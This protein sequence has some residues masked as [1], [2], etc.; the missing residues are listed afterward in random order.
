MKGFLHLLTRF[1][2]ETSALHPNGKAPQW[3]LTL[4]G[5][6]GRSGRSVGLCTGVRPR[7]GWVPCL[8][9]GHCWQALGLTGS[10]ALETQLC[11]GF[12]V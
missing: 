7:V 4:A 1:K 12:E 3:G 9:D 8:P 10:V 11:V 2:P 5:C 6:P